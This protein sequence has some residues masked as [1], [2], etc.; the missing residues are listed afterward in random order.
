[1]KKSQ[2]LEPGPRPLPWQLLPWGI[3]ALVFIA[4]GFTQLGFAHGTL[5]PPLVLLTLFNRRVFQIAAIALAAV[6]LT[7]LGVWISPP[8]PAGF[9]WLHVFFNRLL[10]IVAILISAVLAVVVLRHTERLERVNRRLLVTRDELRN[11]AALMAIAGEMG[12]LGGWSIDVAS[13]RV[14]W[15]EEVA[16]IY[17]MDGDH[18]MDLEDGFRLYAEDDRESLRDKVNR[19]V[20]EGVPYDEEVRLIR[21]DGELRWL[22][23]LGRPEFDD[24]GRPV[25]VLGAVQDITRWKVAED[26]LAR[27]EQRFRELAD[28][29]PMSVWSAD[30]EGR[31]EFGNRAL[32]ELTGYT[33]EAMVAAEGQGYP[34]LIDPR[35]WPRLRAVWRQAVDSG[36]PYRME[37]RL[38][39]RDGSYRWHLMRADLARDEQ[40]VPVKWYG[41]MVDIDDERRRA[42]EFEALADRMSLTLESITDGFLT[43]DRQWRFTFLNSQAQ[44]ITG[45]IAEEVL[46]RCLWEVMPEAVGTESESRYRWAMEHQQPVSFETYYEPL[47][48]WAEVRAYPSAEGLAIFF[49]DISEQRKLESQ[50]REAQR[51]EAVGHL[52]GGMAHDFNNLLTVVLGNG[53]LLRDSL[54]EDSP[55]HPLADLVVD[56]AQRG[57]DLTQRL[58]AFARRQALEPEVVDIN[59]LVGGLETM[60]RR[61]LGGHVEIEWV[62]SPSLWPALVD[63]SQLEN[64]LLNLAINARDSMP[65]GGRLTIETANAR[66]DADYV[67]QHR[68]VRAGP[69]VMVAV[70]DTGTGIDPE[71]LPRVFDPFFSTKEPGRGT[72]LG[73]SMV[74]GFVKQSGGHVNI[75]S[76]PGEG[77]TVR[78]YLPR[79]ETPVTEA[80]ERRR[81]GDD[82]LGGGETIL[83]VEDDAMVRDYAAGVLAAAGYRVLMAEDGVSGLAQLQQGEAIDLLFTDVIMPGGING[84]QLAEQAQALRPGI[85]VLYT[86]GYTENAIVHHGRLDPGLSLLSKP[87]RRAELLA[88]VR[89]ALDG[90]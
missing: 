3:L 4:D 62:R 14:Q 88:K 15:S 50:L 11:S 87:Y 56:A 72:G 25:K 22:R 41:T 67:T 31:M 12:S 34:G 79:A 5:Y 35:D 51:M 37:A 46:G 10:A 19:C 44:L 70:S 28:A 76:E 86:S 63:P 53:E 27:S 16:R 61:T 9:E 66:L 36:Q 8:A 26:S 48:L 52:T 1:M 60:L 84:R 47:G 77:T 29:M 32:L 17:G 78:M 68:E 73:L 39:C 81:V 30:L 7:V 69:Y 20:T 65:K 33:V 75:Y 42:R 43:V 13:G 71:H 49:H 18:E 45:L 2:I 59:R 74:F 80:V 57:A 21:P 23:V 89:R 40:G 54:P 85:R 38:R 64:A 55:L 83:L 90:E 6:V 58:L 82:E 24:Q